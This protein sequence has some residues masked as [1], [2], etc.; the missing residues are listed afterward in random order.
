[1]EGVELVGEA[2]AEELKAQ[3]NEE[4]KNKNYEKAIY[5]YSQALGIN[6]NL[7]NYLDSHTNEGILTNRAASY[8]QV[9]K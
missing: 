8:I 5:C 3:G 7:T 2:R 9:R 1:M 4:F 6:Q